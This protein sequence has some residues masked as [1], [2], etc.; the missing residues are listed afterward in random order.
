MERFLGRL[1]AARLRRC[2]DSRG[3]CGA[4]A[5]AATGCE[6]RVASRYVRR[7]AR[8]FPRGAP[9]SAAEVQF[10]NGVVVL[11]HAVRP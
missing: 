2:V 1:L 10:P 9:S 7:A 5:A 4:G 11:R 3:K 6:R 8:S